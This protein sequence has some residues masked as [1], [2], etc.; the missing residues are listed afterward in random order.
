MPLGEDGCNSVLRTFPTG[1]FL[2]FVLRSIEELVSPF[3]HADLLLSHHPLMILY[4]KCH[5]LSHHAI[6]TILETLM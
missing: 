2:P 5:H 1:A 4:L 3:P 6:A